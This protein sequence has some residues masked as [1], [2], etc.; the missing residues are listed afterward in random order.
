MLCAFELL[1]QRKTTLGAK[2]V[3]CVKDVTPAYL[4]VTSAF[5]LLLPLNGNKTS[6]NKKT[7]L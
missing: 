4:S 2:Q 5:P 7:F 1:L 6:P 3:F